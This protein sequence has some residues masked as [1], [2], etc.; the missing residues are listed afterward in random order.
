[1]NELNTRWAVAILAAGKGT[2]MRSKLP[3]VLHEIAG[4]PLLDHVIDLALEVARP[5]DVVVVVGHGA[6]EVGA[7][8]R[9]RGVS[10]VLQEPQLG[11]GD[12]LRVALD[13]LGG[14]ST[15]H[16]LVLSGDVPLLR[17][18]TLHALMAAVSEGASAALLTAVLDTPG[19]Y[20]RVL[21][22]QDG[23]VCEVVEARDADPDQL[24]VNEVNAGIY[25]FDRPAVTRAVAGLNTDNAQGEYYLTDVVAALRSEGRRVAAV[26][27]EDPEEMQGVNTRADLARAES[28]LNARVLDGL[29][30]SGV[31]IRDPGTIWVDPRSVIGPEV[32]LEPGVVLRGYCHVGAG[33]CIG[34]G[35]VLDSAAVGTGEKVPPLTYLT[36]E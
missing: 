35:C 9:D 7:A 33:A 8:A 5:Q 12:A 15:D 13:G 29:M 19:S 26:Q 27:L 11:T 32:V 23:L 18:G 30:D 21:R 20:G 25:G 22:T 28:A 34:A 24:A 1:M 2:R 6:D 3:K 31:T 4:R 17:S 16:V 36:G 14:R 10:E